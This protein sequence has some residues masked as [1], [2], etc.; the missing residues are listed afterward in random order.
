MLKAMN[1]PLL[2]IEAFNKKGVSKDILD[3][4]KTDVLKQ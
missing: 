3:I 1:I 4:L 2:N